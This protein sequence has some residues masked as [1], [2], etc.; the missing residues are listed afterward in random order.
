MS[1]GGAACTTRVNDLGLR[2]GRGRLRARRSR[3][4]SAPHGL[5][6]PLRRGHT[7]GDTS[8]IYSTDSRT[9]RAPKQS[10]LSVHRD[11]ARTHERANNYGVWVPTGV[12]VDDKHSAGFTRPSSPSRG[13]T[14]LTAFRPARRDSADKVAR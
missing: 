8:H 7:T 12:I 13:E 10:S 6:K 1:R 9:N 2:T 11:Y 14:Q 5:P 4:D 3:R